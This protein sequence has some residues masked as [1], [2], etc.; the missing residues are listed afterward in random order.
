MT[1]KEMIIMMTT[2]CADLERQLEELRKAYN[3][4]LDLLSNQKNELEELKGYRTLWLSL[5]QDVR[6]KHV[7]LIGNINKLKEKGDE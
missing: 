4:N 2:K 7:S 1:D 6:K 5:S 3:F